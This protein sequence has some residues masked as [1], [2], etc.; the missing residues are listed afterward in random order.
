MCPGMLS[1]IL[2]I[3]ENRKNYKKLSNKDECRKAISYIIFKGRVSKASLFQPLVEVGI[4]HRV[5]QM[6]YIEKVY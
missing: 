2:S 5:D 4:H 3:G 1:I 6:V